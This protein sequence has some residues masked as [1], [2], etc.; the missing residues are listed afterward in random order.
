V[1]RIPEPGLGASE[2]SPRRDAQLQHERVLSSRTPGPHGCAG[3]ARAP[4]DYSAS[5][6]RRGRT[7]TRCRAR[8]ASTRRAR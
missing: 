3:P 1:T 8:P 7:P 6:G 5:A 2:P 4:R